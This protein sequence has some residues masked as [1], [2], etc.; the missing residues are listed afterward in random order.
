MSNSSWPYGCKS[1]C[2]TP[3]FF[4]PHCLLEFA[5]ILHLFIAIYFLIVK[6]QTILLI[7]TLLFPGYK[8]KLKVLYIAN[9]CSFFLFSLFE[10]QIYIYP[11]NSF[12]TSIGQ[13][14]FSN[15]NCEFS[16]YTGLWLFYSIPLLIWNIFT[17]LGLSFSLT[18]FSLLF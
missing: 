10:N 16:Q 7:L 4:V 13:Q 8:I 2:S 18:I 12:S 17:N 5:Q 6:F 9:L 15:L 3:G 14:K 1:S 11:F